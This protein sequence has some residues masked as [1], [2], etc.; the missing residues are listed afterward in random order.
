MIDAAL[1]LAR[2][3]IPVFP[4][5][6]DKRPRVRWRDMATTNPQTITRWWED[7]PD[8]VPGV[9]M[10]AASGLFAVDADVDRETGERVGEKTLCELGV[11]VGGYAHRASTP[12][13]GLHLFYRW[14]PD[15]PKNSVK[16]LPGVDTRS[17]GGFVVAWEPDALVSA[18]GDAE[19]EGPPDPLLRALR[20]RLGK[21]L[22]VRSAY[23]S[24]E[25]NRA[26]GGATRSKHL[27]GAAFD[28]AMANHDPAA[29]EAAARKVGFL[30]FGFYPRSGFIHVDL[31]PARQWG[32]RFPVRA[33]AFAA[34]T[35]PAREVLADSRTMKGGGAA[36]VAT[37]GAAGVEVAQSILAETQTA[38]LPLVPHLDTLRWVF[39]AV[40]LGGIA[41]TIYARLDDWRRGRR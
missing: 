10:G 18:R 35:P 32:E 25:H 27:D 5:G 30:G 40:A 31:G 17:D 3:G 21:P 11:D 7:W 9:P 41:V 8:C 16:R 38:I 1:A 19:L 37:L 29:F 33:A 13:G 12:S 4:T 28:I 14:E 22:I 39:I 15:W 26:V 20:D 24:P 36:G 2:A 34:E 6:R 23:R